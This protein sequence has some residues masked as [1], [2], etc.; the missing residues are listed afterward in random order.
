MGLLNLFGGDS[1]SSQQSS[2]TDNSQAFSQSQQ[3]GGDLLQLAPSISLAGSGSLSGL[4]FT[5]YGAIAGAQDLLKTGLADIVN[6]A[7]KQSATAQQT[8]KDALA[9]DQRNSSTS[10]QTT[11]DTLLGLAKWVALAV[12]GAFVAKSI[13]SLFKKG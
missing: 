9:L 10:A 2:N 5:D 8:V 13:F 6:T 1:Q 3:L 11:G 4:Q 7:S 12:A